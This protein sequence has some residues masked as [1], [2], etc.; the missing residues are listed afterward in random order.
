MSGSDSAERAP[1]GVPGLA[2]LAVEKGALRPRSAAQLVAQREADRQLVES[3][4][5]QRH[6]DRQD[7]D[8]REQL[9]LLHLPYARAV[10]GALYGR[11]VHHESEYSDYVQWATLGMIEALDRY[12]PARGAQF[13]TY[14]HARM[15]GAIRNGLEHSSDRL[16]QIG[17]QRRLVSERVAS[18][19][20]GT[21]IED[22]MA[23]DCALLRGMADLGAGMFLAFMLGD[24]AML[25]AEDEVLP[26]GCYEALLYKHEQRRLIEFVGQLSPRQQSVVRLHYLQGLR[27][28]EIAESLGITKGRVSQIHQ[29]ALVR[30]RKLL[31]S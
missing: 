19:R 24:T 26:D 30:L 16:E 25:Q 9:I 29:Q 6:L 21:A 27:F 8:A 10:A 31:A 7:P 5:W 15:L 23:S 20:R 11:H 13:K 4:L 12:D 28:Q 22:P 3:L 2:A 14:A 17:L 1:Y 18:L